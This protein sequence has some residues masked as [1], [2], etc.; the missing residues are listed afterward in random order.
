MKQQSTKEENFTMIYNEYE[1]DV[2]RI[3]F[4]YTKD[5]CLAEE[6]AQAAFYHLFLRFDNVDMEHVRSYLFLTVRNLAYNW[7]RDHKRLTYT[8]SFEMLEDDES[9]AY[10]VEDNYL[11]EEQKAAAEALSR[12]ILTKLREVNVSWYEAIVQVYCLETP[13]EVVA[14]R[15]GVHVDV[16][17]SR[18]YR[19]KQWVRKNYQEQYEEV[20]WWC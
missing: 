2:Y 16:I 15:L 9:F 6:M 8:A 14:L 10:Y 20:L 13:H 18:L 7:F 11:R 1:R 17:H 12:H 5:D 3:A 4:Y 19:A